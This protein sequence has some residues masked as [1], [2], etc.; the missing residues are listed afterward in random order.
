MVIGNWTSQSNNYT[1]TVNGVFEVKTLTFTDADNRF[2]IE[3][4][5]TVNGVSVTTRYVYQKQ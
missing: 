2:Y 4:T 1:F 5:T 3:K